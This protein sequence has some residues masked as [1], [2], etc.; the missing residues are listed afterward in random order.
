MLLY[1]FS[2]GYTCQHWYAQLE[3]TGHKEMRCCWFADCFCRDLTQALQQAALQPVALLVTVRGVYLCSR[4]EIPRWSQQAAFCYSSDSFGG[5]PPP[6]PKLRPSA[7]D[8][9]RLLSTTPSDEKRRPSA[10]RLT[11]DLH[12]TSILNQMDYSRESKEGKPTQ[13]T[14][15]RLDSGLDS[16]R[17]EEY[18]AV[19]AE[20]HRLQVEC[21]PPPHKQAPAVNGELHEWKTQIT[22]DGDT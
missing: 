12:R 15:E 17:E 1:C 6:S 13:A 18:Q 11:M 22:E 21:E 7:E 4:T 14:D 2:P 19:A 5:N 9:Y 8:I 3:S 16:L 10:P 20:I